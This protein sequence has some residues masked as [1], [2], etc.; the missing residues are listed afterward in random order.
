[1]VGSVAKNRPDRIETLTTGGQRYFRI[2]QHF[3]WQRFVFFV[4]DVRRIC[5][6]K[7]EFRPARY[8]CEVITVKERYLVVSFQ[9]DSVSLGDLNR[10]FRDV[11]RR[12]TTGRQFQRQRHTDH[13][14]ADTEVGYSWFG[15][16]FFFDEP[17]GGVAK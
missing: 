5:K 13:A 4:G 14:G 3:G 10:L 17:D 11:Q 7:V 12:D 15:E 6:D 9:V 16:L 2:G 8:L 1:M